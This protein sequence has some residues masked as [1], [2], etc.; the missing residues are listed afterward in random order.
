VIFG[1]NVRILANHEGNLMIKR[2][3]R[4]FEIFNLRGG[5]IMGM[6]SIAMIAISIYSVIADKKIDSSIA[7]MYG[8]AVAAYAASKTYKETQSTTATEVN[9]V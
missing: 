7:G 5:P 4:I 6:W 9:S 8:V 2:I 3:Q 1:G